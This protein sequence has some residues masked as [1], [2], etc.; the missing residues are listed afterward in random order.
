MKVLAKVKMPK[1]SQMNKVK[2]LELFGGIGAIRKAFINL[3]IPYLADYLGWGGL[4]DVFD[5]EKGGQW[6]EARN[7]LKENLTNEEYIAC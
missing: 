7:I 6:L 2:I 3:K 5:E 1:T 4:A